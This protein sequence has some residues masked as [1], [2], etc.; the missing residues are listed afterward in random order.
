M[1]DKLKKEIEKY[2]LRKDGILIRKWSV[3]KNKDIKN[4]IQKVI[5]ATQF[6]DDNTEFRARIYAILND[7]TVKP[8]CKYSKCNNQTKY[9]NR[10]KGFLKYCSLECRKKANAFSTNR[11]RKFNDDFKKKISNSIKKRGGHF[12]KNNPNYGN[13]HSEKTKKLF[14]EQRKGKKQTKEHVV[15]R[16]ATIEK[17][18]YIRILKSSKFNKI[19]KPLFTLDEYNGTTKEYSWKCLKCGY[20]FKDTIKSP[21]L[22]RCPKCFPIKSSIA[23]N[24]LADW[25]E[26][27]NVVVKR[28]SKIIYP[29]EVDIYL[30][31]YNL[32]IEYDSLYWHCERNENIDKNYHIHKTELC[33]SKGIQLLHIFD[34]EWAENTEIIKS[35]ILNKLKKTSNK[36]YARN[37]IVKEISNSLYRQFTEVNHLQ[38]YTPA[39]I[40][41]GLFYNN[42]LVQILTFAIPRFNYQYDYEIIRFA[43]LINNSVIGGFSKLFSYF[44]K[45]YEFKSIITYADRRYS[46]GDVYTKNGFQFITFSKPNYYYT[47]DYKTLENRLN[48]QKHKLKDKLKTFDSTLTE[49]EN[50][51]LN[52]YDRIWDCGNLVLTYENFKKS[53]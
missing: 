29:Y 47:K 16:I 18:F 15:K 38:G 27:L 39:N 48:Y 37:T 51:Q 44:K 23:E 42:I 11:G 5:N 14:S 12:G 32:A 8:T 3:A 10:Q 28:R 31:E 49:W 45:H 50:M 52:G 26:N 2:L 17:N 1:N 19:I 13:K 46:T 24:L 36:I 25:I 9:F 21:H 33:Q 7:I 43:T 22:P 53:L 35:I 20:T 34:N 4:I 30:P 40:K 6:L 41:L